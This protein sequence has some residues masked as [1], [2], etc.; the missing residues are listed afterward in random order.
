MTDTP[1]FT[2]LLTDPATPA[3]IASTLP[4]RLDLRERLGRGV[5]SKETARTLDPFTIEPLTLSRFRPLGWDWN[6]RRNFFI[7]ETS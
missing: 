5:M 6:G 2:A 3:W 7:T 1:I 4:Q